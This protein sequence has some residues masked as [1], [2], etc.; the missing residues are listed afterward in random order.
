MRVGRFVAT[1]VGL[2]L[3]G[4]GSSGPYS[5]LAQSRTEDLPGAPGFTL[6]PPGSVS[7]SVTPQRAIS[8]AAPKAPSKNVVVSLARVPSGYVTKPAAGSATTPVWVVM[9]RDSCY[10]SAKGE[11]VSASRK[12]AGGTRPPS[13]TEDNIWA[14]MV[15]VR[16]GSIVGGVP[17]YDVSGNWRPSVG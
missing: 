15:D 8:V 17:G 6:S 2:L 5:S 16:S 1:L 4:C 10:A 3:V 9:V 12:G 14:A 13:C 11:L 7:V